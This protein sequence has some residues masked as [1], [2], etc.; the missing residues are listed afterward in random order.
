MK[1]RHRSMCSKPL[2]REFRYLIARNVGKESDSCHNFDV[3]LN[4]TRAAAYI[5]TDRSHHQ[6]VLVYSFN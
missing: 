3:L 5:R 4:K 2:L 1:N 6:A